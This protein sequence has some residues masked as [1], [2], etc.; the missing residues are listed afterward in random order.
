MNE[1]EDESM[2][3]ELFMVESE[4]KKERQS[5]PQYH[6]TLQSHAAQVDIYYELLLNILIKVSQ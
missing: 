1:K 2:S 3:Y 4:L 5:L 6:M